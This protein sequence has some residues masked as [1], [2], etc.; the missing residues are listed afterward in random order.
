[1]VQGNGVS[2]GAGQTVAGVAGVGQAGDYFQPF[3]PKEI[4]H[5]HYYPFGGLLSMDNTGKALK[6]LRKLIEKEIIKDL[7]VAQFIS[8]LDDISKEL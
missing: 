1:M 2:A 7:T 5:N 6:I 3:M 4:H 8:L